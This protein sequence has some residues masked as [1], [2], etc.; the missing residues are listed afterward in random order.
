VASKSRIW[1][2]RPDAGESVIL[3]IEWRAITQEGKTATNYQ[4]FPGDRIYVAAHPLTTFDTVLGRIV[5]PA[6]RIFGF[7]L[8]GNS[9]VRGFRNNNTNGSNNNSRN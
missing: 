9:T 1:L 8:L 4:I 5:A 3:P 2:A 6:E 7:T